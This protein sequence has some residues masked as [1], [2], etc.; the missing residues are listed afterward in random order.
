MRLNEEIINNER[1][2]WAQKLKL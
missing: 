1:N 2:I